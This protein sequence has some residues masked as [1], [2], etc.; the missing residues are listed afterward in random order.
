MVRMEDVVPVLV[1]VYARVISIMEKDVN[2]KTVD[3]MDSL[4]IRDNVYVERDSPETYAIP[5]TR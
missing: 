3:C 4:T 5:V 2:L 1:N